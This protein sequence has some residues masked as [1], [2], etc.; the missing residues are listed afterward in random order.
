MIYVKIIITLKL[1]G[2]HLKTNQ[3]VREQIECSAT[4]PIC[5]GIGIAAAHS[6]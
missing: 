3:P 5:S 4:I 1:S 6:I 2:K